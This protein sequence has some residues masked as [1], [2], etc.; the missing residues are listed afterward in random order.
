MDKCVEMAAGPYHRTVHVTWAITE[1][2]NPPSTRQ[3]RVDLGWKKLA[4][5]T[6]HV[7]KEISQHAAAAYVRLNIIPDGGVARLR[8]WGRVA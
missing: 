3:S 1:I 4:A 2:T 7:F 6:K 5:N 8:L